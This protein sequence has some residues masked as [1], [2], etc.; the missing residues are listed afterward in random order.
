MAYFGHHKTEYAMKKLILLGF[1]LAISMSMFSQTQVLSSGAETLIKDTLTNEQD[2]IIKH[3]ISG[4]YSWAWH[5]LVDT[6]TGT[7]DATVELVVALGDYGATPPDSAFARMGTNM[8]GTLAL[9]STA[10]A[11]PIS[12][13]SEDGIPYS[14]IGLRFK[15]E[16]ITKWDI[17]NYLNLR[18]E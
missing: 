9:Y 4:D 11:D 13:Y 3:R 10:S 6:L 12:F 8:I 16:S 15:K 7:P 18:K 5:V 2:T 1:A 14:W 17:R